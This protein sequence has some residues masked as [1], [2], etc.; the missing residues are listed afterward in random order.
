LD[1]PKNEPGTKRGWEK[2]G[3]SLFCAWV[4][5][6]KRRRAK[7]EPSQ[8]P[9]RVGA[10]EIHWRQKKTPMP[11]QPQNLPAR[12]KKKKAKHGC[13]KG[14]EKKGKK[15][16]NRCWGKGKRPNAVENNRPKKGAINRVPV[17]VGENF[18]HLPTT[19]RGRKNAKPAA[20]DRVIALHMK[21]NGMCRGK[22]RDRRYLGPEHSR[23]NIEGKIIRG[24]GR[25]RQKRS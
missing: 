5:V 20:R 18:P 15:K 7:T 8:R 13:G 4:G 16:K 23:G 3:T 10:K 14:K 11:Q 12:I 6:G 22:K 17:S 1:G 25:G 24:Q 19:S 9:N 21:H 2:T